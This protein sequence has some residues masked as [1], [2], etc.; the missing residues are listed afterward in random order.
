MENDNLVPT[1]IYGQ[2]FSDYF[3]KYFF[4]GNCFNLSCLCEEN[5]KDLMRLVKKEE[6]D[7]GPGKM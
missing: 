7:L 3:Q 6:K 4:E 2:F 5:R 1:G